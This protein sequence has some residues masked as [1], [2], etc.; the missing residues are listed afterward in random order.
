MF[1]V[2]VCFVGLNLHLGLQI[3]IEKYIYIWVLGCC[4]DCICISTVLF[5]Q[6]CWITVVGFIVIP[7][8]SGLLDVL[9][10]FVG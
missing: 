3:R 8:I 10:S 4:L 9:M 1:C 7:L 2:L 6:L 5:L